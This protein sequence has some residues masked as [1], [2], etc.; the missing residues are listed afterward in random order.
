MRNIK[1]LFLLFIVNS[2]FS[3][4]KVFVVDIKDEIDFSMTHSVEN[5]LK[6]ATEQKADFILVDMNT[7]GGLLDEADKIKTM[8]LNYPK[9]VWV[10]VN[11]NA[12]SAGALLSLACDS[13]YMAGGASIGA[14]TVVN[15]E[16]GMALPDKYQSY[17]RSKMRAV[18]E[19][20]HRD[21]SLAEAMVDP[22]VKLD[23][24]IKKDGQVLTLTT[25]EAIK[26]GICD[27][28]V[29]SYAEIFAHN[30]LK[31]PTVLKYNSTSGDGFFKFLMND[32][33]T[34]IIIILI[35]IALFVELGSFTGIPSA[36]I[37]VLGLLFFMPRYS[38]G[39]IQSWEVIILGVGIVLLLL[40]I[41][42]IPGFGLV[43]ILGIIC[44]LGSLGLMMVN[45]DNLDF[46]L[47]SPNSVTNT[48]VI[49]FLAILVIVIAF[50]V[51]SSK[52][53]DN[54]YF[55]KLVLTE[56]LTPNTEL[57]H[58]EKSIVSHV[59]LVHQ[60]GI[61]HTDLR[62]SG[63]I[64]LN[65]EIYDAVTKGDFVGK[66]KN[67]EVVAVYNNSLVVKEVAV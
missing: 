26:Y 16:D 22:N 20:N 67:I 12:A 10:Y 2:L 35:L 28:K 30:N 50:F 32:F 38:A 25:N 59:G 23:S 47:V 58:I 18:A 27:K 65:G 44:V 57:N 21:T 40:E 39:L 53:L 14:A 46:G 56:T 62:P 29:N 55:R 36:A 7:Y 24:S 52:L 19:A 48:V 43:G 54:K 63:K 8:L 66:G 64:E 13:I 5:A 15:G 3:Q 33:V 11:D 9:P 37:F 61:A 45:N 1:I 49:L 31:N 41:F 17:M 60:R 51:L 34:G 42:V 4:K 6:K